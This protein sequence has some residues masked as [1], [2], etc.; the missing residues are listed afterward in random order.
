MDQDEI[1]AYCQTQCPDVFC[2]Q[3]RNQHEPQA[4]TC[5]RARYESLAGGNVDGVSDQADNTTE[6]S[7]PKAFS[8]AGERA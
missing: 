6:K 1:C 2:P 7:E 4:V 3:N 8:L 5:C